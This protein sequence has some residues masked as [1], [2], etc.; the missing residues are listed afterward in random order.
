MV[1]MM[2]QLGKR[3][4]SGRVAQV[5]GGNLYVNAGQK[6]GLDVGVTLDVFRPGKEIIDPVTKQKLG[7]TENKVGQAIVQKNDIGDQ[8]DL[9]VAAP[10][11]G[12]DFKA[13]DIVRIAASRPW[14]AVEPRLRFR[15][16]R[17]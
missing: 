10:T 17:G 14:S 16:G 12:V 15:D 7:M 5:D 11:S 4:W 1:N 6:S 8:G 9:S 2:K 3:T 13:G